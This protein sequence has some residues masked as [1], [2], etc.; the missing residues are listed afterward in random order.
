MLVMYT[1]S[2]SDDSVRMRCL[3]LPLPEDWVRPATVPW[4]RTVALGI[5]SRLSRDL[6]I[7]AS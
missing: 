3:A 1:A 6:T 5:L 7:Q 4:P 2:I